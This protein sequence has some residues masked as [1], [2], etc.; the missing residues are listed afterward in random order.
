MENDKG[1]TV[2]R[3]DETITSTHERPQESYAPTGR[4]NINDINKRN[5]EQEKKEKKSSYTTTGII[6][7]SIA[8]I[9]VVVY[10]LS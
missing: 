9:I 7:L 10:F 6:V 5:A 3:N 1:Q 8:F 2:E 4:T